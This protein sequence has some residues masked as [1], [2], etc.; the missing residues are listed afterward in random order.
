[1][2]VEPLT[3]QP[4][5]T[6]WSPT[7]S[8]P[9]ASMA[10]AVAS[11]SLQPR[12]SKPKC[13]LYDSTRTGRGV[14]PPS[15]G[16][17]R[18]RVGRRDREQDRSQQQDHP[19]PDR[20]QLGPGHCAEPPAGGGSLREGGRA[21]QTRTGPGS[22]GRKGGRATETP[23]GGGS[24]G[25]EGSRGGRGAAAGFHSPHTPPVHRPPDRLNPCS[26]APSTKAGTL[27]LSGG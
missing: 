17:G 4:R 2:S 5:E 18:H 9:L 11:R 10:R 15:P 23:A 26:T 25:R 14:P 6:S 27:R 12:T 3:Y 1:M 16:R 20:H 13:R 7:T 19:H 22:P 24:P 8:A 21:A